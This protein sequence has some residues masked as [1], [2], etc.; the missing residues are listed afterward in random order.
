MMDGIKN[1]L[2]WYC[3]IFF[4][5]SCR[6]VIF[7]FEKMVDNLLG[8]LFGFFRL[9]IYRFVCSYFGVRMCMSCIK[10]SN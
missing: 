6:F 10:L 8:C 9:W 3:M 2:V 1:C 7:W 4:G 5:V